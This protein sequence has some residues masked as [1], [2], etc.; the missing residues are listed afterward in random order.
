[1]KTIEFLG[2]DNFQ[3]ICSDFSLNQKETEIVRQIIERW[4]ETMKISDREAR[5]NEKAKIAIEAFRKISPERQER[6]LGAIVKINLFFA[7]F[8]LKR[9]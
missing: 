3:K 1:M 6:V 7:E 9:S 2:E 5:L 4:D 8:S